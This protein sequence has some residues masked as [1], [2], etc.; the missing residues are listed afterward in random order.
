MN[1]KETCEPYYVEPSTEDSIR[2]TRELI[3]YIRGLHKH[4]HHH[5]L[6]QPI[7]T[8]RFALSCTPDLLASLGKLALSDKSLAI[9]THISENLSEIEATAELFSKEVL[10]RTAINPNRLGE[11]TYAGVYDAYGLLRENTILAHAV[12]FGDEEIEVVRKRKT[13]ISH[14]PTS[15]FNLRSGCAKVG[16]FLDHGVKVRFYLWTFIG[17]IRF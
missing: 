13:G 12:H 4:H 3:T 2:D 1:N 9:Q 8:P 16:K 17:H 5:S 6:V 14:C 7:L 15:N 10:D 11:G